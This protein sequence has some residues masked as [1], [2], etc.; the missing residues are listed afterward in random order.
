MQPLNAAQGR[1]F[2]RKPA[3]P[4]DQTRRPARKVDPN[5]GKLSYRMVR[6]RTTPMVK[7]GL[8]IWLPLLVCCGTVG[9]W[10]SSAENRQ[11][12]ND[13]WGEFRSQIE[14]RPEFRIDRVTLEGA[15]E[16][17]DPLVRAVLPQEFP[18]SSLSLD[19]DAL[20]DTVAAL[21]QV[22]RATLRVQTG[23]LLVVLEERVPQA[24]W[25]SPEG[26]VLLD[27]SGIVAG[28]AGARADWPDLPVVAGA[29][30]D[31]AM[32][33]LL[34]LLEAADPIRSRLRGFER[35][36][37]R[38]WD[39]VLDH[40]QRI[41]LPEDDPLSALERV[42]AMDQAQDLLGREAHIIDFRLPDRPTLRLDPEQAAPLIQSN[43]EALRSGGHP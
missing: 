30:A 19:L 2:H 22:A 31:V 16:R 6:W 23:E 41:M 4:G 35:R 43:A 33:E 5:G 26:L 12:F 13:M 1:V 9:L 27:A 37:A 14:G 38:R 10:A 3:V 40:D 21:P 11:A 39:V 28:P 42:I 8:R 20:R 24:L 32:A 15:S 17:V 29:G 34:T 36:G 7:T 25:R 18:Q